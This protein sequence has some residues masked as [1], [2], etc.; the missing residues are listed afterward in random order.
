MF[1]AR[2]GGADLGVVRMGLDMLLQILRALESLAAE[3]AFVRLKWHMN[4][5]MGG[6]VIT[7]DCCGV[8]SAPL[9]GQV[10]VVGTFTSNVALTNMLLYNDY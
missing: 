8:A 4:T 9:A 6:N 5:N 7:L 1:H 10:E 2:F 3:V